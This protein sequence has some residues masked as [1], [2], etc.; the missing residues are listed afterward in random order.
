MKTN[1]SKTKTKA[2]LGAAFMLL[3]AL[4]FTACPQKVKPKAEEAP[5]APPE[6][7]PVAYDKLAEYLQKLP[8]SDTVHKIEVTGLKKEHLKGDASNWPYT[9][10]PL[11]AILN[12]APTKKVA[13]KLGGGITGL[14]DMQACFFQCKS[15]VQITAIPKGVTNMH[16]CFSRCRELT[17]APAI[18]EGVQNMERCFQDCEKLT[19]VPALPASVTE[20]EGCFYNCKSL[21]QAPLLPAG[22]TNLS[23]CFWGCKSL[24][25]PPEIPENVTNIV[26]CFEGCGKIKGVVLKCNYRDGS[27]SDLFS[28]C[29]A[30]KTGS[31]KVPQ[32]Q[33]QNYKNNAGKMKT[34]PNN[35]SE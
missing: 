21:T 1:N 25:E 22:I 13:L 28:R 7:T 19:K 17:K 15:L 29:N 11:G 20:M 16:E 14:T 9:L 32:G 5:A 35:F 31:I 10:S 24:T 27:F 30:L 8:A 23:T 12:A 2:F 6:Y 3:I 4:I 33:L 26:S 18:P 34:N